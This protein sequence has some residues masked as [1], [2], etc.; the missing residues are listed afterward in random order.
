MDESISTTGP[1]RISRIR[2]ATFIV[3]IRLQISEFFMAFSRLSTSTS[4]AYGVS[5]R[6]ISYKA[7]FP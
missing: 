7:V 5:R 4:F 1:E 2:T 3:P 6:C